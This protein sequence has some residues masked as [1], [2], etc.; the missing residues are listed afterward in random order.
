M[1]TTDG[2]GGFVRQSW[3]H[4]M[5]VSFDVMRRNLH[6]NSNNV[7]RIEVNVIVFFS[8]G[9]APAPFAIGPDS[10]LYNQSRKRASSE[11]R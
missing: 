10:K 1:I 4:R 11:S 5:R 6:R 2:F 7:Y 9:P 3:I 8:F